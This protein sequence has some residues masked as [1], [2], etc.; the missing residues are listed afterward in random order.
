MKIAHHF[1]FLFLLWPLISAGAE[2]QGRV[3]GVLDGDTVDVLVSEH[4]SYRIRLAG[5]DAPERAQPFGKVAKQAMSDLVMGRDVRVEY[6]KRDRYGRIIGVV[7][8]GGTDAGM[9]L[10]EQGLAWHYKRYAHE[11]KPQQRV[12][13]DEAENAARVKRSGLWADSNPTPPWEWRRRDKHLG[14]AQTHATM[15]VEDEHRVS[16]SNK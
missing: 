8:A 13:Y 7:M 14:T 4:D 6:E 12:D 11:Q 9:G 3:V 1:F 2:L 5:I 10:I 15:A 16:V